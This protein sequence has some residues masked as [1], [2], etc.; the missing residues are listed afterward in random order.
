MG[1]KAS[2]LHEHQQSIEFR[3]YVLW[4]WNPHFLARC[5][6]FV[7]PCCIPTEMPPYSHNLGSLNR[8]GLYFPWIPSRP[9]APRFRTNPRATKVGINQDV[10]RCDPLWIELNK[11][12]IKINIVNKTIEPAMGL[13]QNINHDPLL[14]LSVCRRDDSKK[15]P[16]TRPSAIG[17]TGICKKAHPHPKN[18]K[19]SAIK[20]P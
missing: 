4:T 6:F 13:S 16:M 18:P 2:R 1:Y 11:G 12:H 10:D 15:S 8:A 19:T 17:I 7:A 14:M 3:T 9:P 20:T 5:G